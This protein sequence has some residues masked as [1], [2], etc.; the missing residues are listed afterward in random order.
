MV[1]NSVTFLNSIFC[2][3]YYI[4]NWLIPNYFNIISLYVVGTWVFLYIWH[5]FKLI[6]YKYKIK[7][8]LIVILFFIQL[9]KINIGT[10]IHDFY[11]FFR[12]YFYF[13]SWLQVWHTALF[14]ECSLHTGFEQV[15]QAFR[16][17]RCLWTTSQRTWQLLN[18]LIRPE[19]SR[20]SKSLGTA[21]TWCIE[22]SRTISVA[23]KIVPIILGVE[24]RFSIASMHNCFA[25]SLK[26]FGDDQLT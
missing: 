12:F 19:A 9:T 5:T 25:S 22:R 1:W 24:A 11:K 3:C 17:L 2:F 20:E 21:T 23:S 15:E 8:T 6:L 18:I 16:V 10:I 4:F 26:F 7:S 14:I 13:V